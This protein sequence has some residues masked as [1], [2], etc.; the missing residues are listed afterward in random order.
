MVLLSAVAAV[1]AGAAAGSDL[2][3]LEQVWP[4]VRD[5]AETVFLSSGTRINPWGE[6]AERRVRT[7]VSRLEAPAVGAHVL[8]MEEFLHD[9]PENVRRQLLLLLEPAQPSSAGVHVRVFT[10]RQPGA[11]THL[12]RRPARAATL[13]RA[14]LAE[15]VGCDLLLQREGE[16]FIGGTLGNRC[17][18]IREGG[19]RYI[20]LQLVISEDLYWYR[21]RV[22]LRANDDLLEEVSGYNWLELDEAR[23]FSCR[24]D[25]SASGRRSELRPLLRTELHDEGGHAHFGTPDGRNLELVLHSQD[26]PFMAD[27]DA[28]ILLLQDQDGSRP[29]ATAWNGIDAEDIG[30]D[31]GWLRIHCGSLLPNPDA[32]LAV[33]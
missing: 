22:L 33:R 17:L 16:Q 21:R 23:L 12:D 8:Y 4:G 30:I 13:R 20:D 15:A 29:L 32:L 31:L 9:D 3:A 18:D 28:L 1:V 19:R 10:L 24:I 2:S 11:L 27:R 26:W 7:I 5:S 14:D 25:W 6:G